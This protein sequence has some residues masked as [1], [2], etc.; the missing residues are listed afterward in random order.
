[1]L[2]PNYTYDANGVHISEYL[3]P[4]GY[5]W[6]SDA[7]ARTAGC[8]PGSLYKKNQKLSGGTGKAEYITIHNTADLPNIYDDGEQYTRAT[9]PNENMGTSRVHF[10]VDDTG[11][12][13]NLKAG[14]GTP[15]DPIGSAEVGW[16]AADGS[17][18]GGGNMTSIAIEIIEKESAAHDAVARDNGARLA[19]WLLHKHRLPISRLV[20][21]SYW[22]AKKAGKTCANV[23]EQCVVNVGGQHYC[24]LYIFGS[25]NKATA[26]KNWKAFKA[27]VKAYLDQLQGTAA[28]SPGTGSGTTETAWTVQVG[29][30]KVLA[31]AE[32]RRDKVKAAGFLA[33]LY[34]VGQLYKVY[35]GSYASK[36]EAQIIRSKLITVGFSATV[37][38]Q[39]GQLVEADDTIRVGDLVQCNPGVKTYSNGTVMPEWVSSAKL[40]VRMIED[41]G[42]IYLVSTEPERN[43]FTGRFRAG[44]V[45]KV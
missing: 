20:T 36:N 30:Y 31:N 8:A 4:D 28:P 13:Q 34:L 1:M 11:G 9:Y 26:L 29:A 41:G 16:H 12:W 37:T 38:Q 27:T 40:Y 18:A 32:A 19:A 15:H 44:D 17:I 14:I 25:T 21:H 22:N 5:R 43:I 7:K 24:P 3:I 42:A 2:T 23:D 45:H 39:S 10:Y 33:S 6:K 35:V